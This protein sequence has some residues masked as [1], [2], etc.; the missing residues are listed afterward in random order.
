MIL[1]EA[2]FQDLR[3]AARML[4]RNPGFTTVAVLALGLGIGVNTA[5]FTAYQA[6]I[7][8]PLDARNPG[9]MVN[10]GLV[11]GSVAEAPDPAFSYPDYEAYRDTV[12]S[13]QGVIAFSVFFKKTADT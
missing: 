8:R 12:R 1:R 5:V 2:L 13:F 4:C 6:M 11:R 9:E 10:L 7:A 3:Y